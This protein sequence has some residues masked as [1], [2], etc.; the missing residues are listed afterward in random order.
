MRAKKW[1]IGLQ[2]E[3]VRADE[4]GQRIKK[5]MLFKFDVGAAMLQ[6][7]IENLFFPK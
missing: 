6:M 1:E 2:R 5:T 3:T 7:D 4:P